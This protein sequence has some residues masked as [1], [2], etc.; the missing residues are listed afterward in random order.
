MAG[1]VKV[2][3][4]YRLPSP[5]ERRQVG[6]F[7]GVAVEVDVFGAQRSGIGH[8][9]FEIGRDEFAGF[10]VGV[11]EPAIGVGEAIPS[12]VST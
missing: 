9:R 5:V 4:K 3:W 2:D 1:L 6:D 12:S 10:L 11:D 7:Q 8:D